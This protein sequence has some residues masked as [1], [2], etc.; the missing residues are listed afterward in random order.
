MLL[1]KIYCLFKNNINLG[2]IK[3]FIFNPET[4]NVKDIN[5]TLKTLMKT[6]P[7]AVLE[8]GNIYLRNAI[9]KGMQIQNKMLI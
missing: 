7:D 4:A 8:I 6:N 1:K 3:K 5:A 9:N 2:T